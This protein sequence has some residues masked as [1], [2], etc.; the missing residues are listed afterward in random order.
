MEAGVPP[1][2]TARYRRATDVVRVKSPTKPVIFT[3]RPVSSNASLMAL[4]CSDSSGSALPFGNV[5]RYPPK[6]L[7]GP[8]SQ[9]R[10]SGSSTITPELANLPRSE[11]RRG[12]KDGGSTGRYRGGP[13]IK[14]KN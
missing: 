5:D 4:A 9:T 13:V 12:G 10:P 2:R 14:K 3:R 6:P 7:V 8:T 11:T 1:T